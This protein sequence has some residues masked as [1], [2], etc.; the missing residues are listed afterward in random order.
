MRMGTQPIARRA[1]TQTGRPGSGRDRQAV[2]YARVS[3][4]E[5]DQEGYSIPAQVS[6]TRA[7]A[8]EQELTLVREFSD[9]ETAKKGWPVRL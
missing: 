7:Y 1:R 6:L 2:G 4:K 9:V 3:S 5:Q 8:G